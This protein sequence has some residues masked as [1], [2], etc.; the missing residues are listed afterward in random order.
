MSRTNRRRSIVGALCIAVLSA[1]LAAAAEKGWKPLFNGK[2]LTGWRKTGA[3]IFKVE[4]GCLVGT[5]T[6]G[7]GGDLWTEAQY[8]NFELRVTYRVGWPANSGFW[9]RHDGR[10]GYQY[11][12]LKYKRPVA[13]SGTMYCPGKMFI[14]RNLNESLEN[15]DGWNEARL[16]AEGDELTL[17]LNGTKVGQCR[18]DLLSKGAIGIQVHGGG[19]KGMKIIIKKMEVLPLAAPPAGGVRF[20]LHR[21][22]KYRSEACGVGDFNG[23][24][25]MDIIAGPFWYEAPKW[26]AHK[27]RELSG[28]V[29]ADG[30]GYRDDFMNTPLDVD[31][32][33]RLDLVTCGWFCKQM[34]WFRNTGKPTGAWPMTVAETNGN[35][36]TGELCDVDGDGKVDEIVPATQQTAWF[37]VG[38]DAGGKRGLIRY[39][40]CPKR[41]PFGNGVGDVNGDGRPDL[42][43]PDV[44]FEAPKDPRKGKWTEHPVTLGSIDPNK[45]DHTPQILVYDVDGDGA[46]DIITSSAHK[47]GIFWY[48]QVR[49]GKQVTW[50]QNVIDKSWSQAHSLTLGDLDGDGDLDLVTGKRY[51][52]HNGGDPGSS[53]PPGVY[54]YEL[55]RKG[56]VTWTQHVISYGQGIGSALNAAVA[57]MDGDGDLDIVVTG[58]WGGPVYFENKLKSAAK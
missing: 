43:R 48:R 31:G 56:G 15:R 57:D 54:W 3:G 21:V 22:G 7:K 18:D 25:K 19:F 11:D 12:V 17:W 44:W 36:E 51:L 26:K 55:S 40:V 33:G 30:K 28:K 41:R 13:F 2:D 1:G 16:R 8:D 5:Q 46:N 9:F 38:V 47:Y 49:K 58:K 20:V 45:A 39:D 52:A 14:T 42:L 32:D 53:D 35:Y 4:D 37:E 6:D 10:K 29:T 50:Q 24:G 23:D 27:F 34:Q